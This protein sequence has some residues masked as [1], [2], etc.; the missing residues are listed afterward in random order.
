[1]S[2]PW[3]CC[4][5][6]ANESGK[7]LNADESQEG[8]IFTLCAITMNSVLNLAFASVGADAEGLARA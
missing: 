5:Y 7:R 6:I 8:S 4:G 1:M 2:R 3:L